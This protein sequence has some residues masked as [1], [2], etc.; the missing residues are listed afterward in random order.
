[1]TPLGPAA[2]RGPM[3]ARARMGL[4]F[5]RADRDGLHWLAAMAW[6]FVLLLAALLSAPAH[7]HPAPFSYLDLQLRGDRID[8]TLAVHMTD[9]ARE[10]KLPT[11]DMLIDDEEVQGQR[12]NIEKLLTPRLMLRGDAPLR[13]VWTEIAPQADK[14]QLRLTFR[15]DGPPP[16]RLDVRTD[17]FPSDRQH[18]TIVNLYE[19]DTLGEQW[20]FA[21]GSPTRS[22]FAGTSAGA[23]AVLQSF[24][25]SGIHHILIGPDHILFLVGL[26]LLGGRFA[27]MV[28]IVTAFTIGHS[29]TLALAALN[30]VTPP[31]SIIEP[32]I[33]LTIIFVGADNLLRGEGRD[34][35]AYEAGVFGLVH[36]FGFANVLRESGLPTQNLLLSLFG[37]NVGVELGQ[38]AIVVVIATLVDFIWKRSAIMGYRVAVAGS[39]VVIAMGGYWF[40]ERIF[41]PGGM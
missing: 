15:V 33:A 5:S 4:D 19:G 24:L 26:M 1:M 28:K 13:V 41:F 9:V 12:A 20:I 8:G 11:P 2:T 31:A 6:V 38:L 37:F 32:A 17:L 3:D 18:Q 22:Y 29:V 35:R 10:L 14:A 40:V 7:G 16:A 21:R 30:L 34:L 25:P 36:G 23:L 39:V 27:Q